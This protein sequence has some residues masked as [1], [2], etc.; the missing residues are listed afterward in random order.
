MSKDDVHP[1]GIEL[2]GSRS[3]YEPVSPGFSE[4]SRA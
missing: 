1:P 4:E 2:D 3:S